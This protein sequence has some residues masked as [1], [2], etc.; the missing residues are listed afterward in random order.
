MVIEV[1]EGFLKARQ[2]ANLTLA[3][4]ML[5]CV[6][7]NKENPA[8]VRAVLKRKQPQFAFCN[9]NRSRENRPNYCKQPHT[10]KTTY[11]NRTSS[12]L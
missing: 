3:S 9:T 10:E 4:R 8:V 11:A 1:L 5:P 6:M 12:Q 2:K 7:D